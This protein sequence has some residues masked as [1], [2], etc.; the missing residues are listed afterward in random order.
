MAPQRKSHKVTQASTKVQPSTKV[1]WIFSAH[2]QSSAKVRVIG[3]AFFSDSLLL[4]SDTFNYAVIGVKKSIFKH[5]EY[6]IYGYVQ[7]K[8]GRWSSGDLI[9]HVNYPINCYS[10]GD[11]IWGRVEKE[12][13]PSEI[14]AHIRSMCDIRVIEAGEVRKKG[15]KGTLKVDADDINEDESE[16]CSEEESEDESEMNNPFLTKESSPPAES[17]GIKRKQTKSSISAV[18]PEFETKLRKQRKSSN[19]PIELESENDDGALL[20]GFVVAEKNDRIASTSSI[21]TSSKRNESA[22]SSPNRAAVFK[23]NESAVSS[24]NR[25]AVHNKNMYAGLPSFDTSATNHYPKD[26]LLNSMEVMMNRIL[27]AH[28]EVFQVKLHNLVDGLSEKLIAAAVIPSDDAAAHSDT[29]I[30]NSEDETKK[31]SNADDPNSEKKT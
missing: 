7:I 16:Y 5:N 21:A 23:R 25:L 31:P 15:P 10:S 18:E 13:K 27:K 11:T 26:T 28:F 3:N 29:N 12:F 14:V 17:K 2:R 4:R 8:H 24:P 1:N 6:D 20:E 22:I 19:S 9:K 30:K